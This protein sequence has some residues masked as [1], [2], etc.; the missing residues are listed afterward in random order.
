MQICKNDIIKKILVPLFFTLVV[1]PV[2]AET[3]TTTAS[4]IVTNTKSEMSQCSTESCLK[5]AATKAQEQLNNADD[6][7]CANK[8][9][10]EI[11]T[12]INGQAP[13]EQSP[14]VTNSD[15]QTYTE[16]EPKDP[17]D[18]AYTTGSQAWACCHATGDVYAWTGA[19]CQCPEEGAAWDASTNKC[20][21]A[22]EQK[23]KAYDEAKANEQSLAN[24][25]LTAVTTAAT[26]IGG[27]ELARGLAEQKADK[28]AEQDMAAYIATFRCTYGDGHQ[29]KAGPEEIELPGGN[30]AT[31]MSLRNEYFTLASD[32]KER[33]E[34]LG[35]TPGIESE[36]ILD[37]SEMGLYDD[38]NV[39]IESGAYASIY[40]ATVL[41]S[42]EDQAKIDEERKASKNRVIGGAVAAGVGVVGGIVGNSLINGKLSEK[43]KEK[44]EKKRLSDM[45]EQELSE[46]IKDQETI[47]KLIENVKQ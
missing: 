26:G 38:E 24:R 4:A 35:L 29:V 43:I 16:P 44:S 12:A 46:F 1:F 7:K 37:K 40:R 9:G 14:T 28:E 27:M 33:K 31:M 13:A 10:D 23:Q 41:E 30:D 34:A 42:E 21:S 19:T 6:T 45:S 3:K 11:I 36:T 20:I 18:D 2:F 32:L 15:P 8:N 5:D 17:C 39:G 22:L 25:T 47:Q